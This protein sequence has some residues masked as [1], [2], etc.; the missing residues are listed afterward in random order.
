MGHR[1]IAV[2]KPIMLTPSRQA[3]LRLWLLLAVGALAVA[4]ALALLLALSRTPKIQDWLPW[5]SDFFH[6]GLVT[7]VV[8]SVV[9]WFL[10]MLGA[11]T[12]ATRP[13]GDIWAR[14]GLVAAAAGSLLLLVPTLAGWGDSSLNNYVPVLDHPL[15]YTGLALLGGGIALASAP[16]LRDIRLQAPVLEFGIAIGALGVISAL[17]C[18]GLA[19]ALIPAGTDRPFFNERLFWG[20]GHV[21]Q[22]VNTILMMAA[23]HAL[24]ITAFGRP[25]LPPAAARA[26]FASLGLFIL[27]APLLYGLDV[28]GL[29]HRVAFTQLLWYGLALPPLVMGLGVAWLLVTERSDT[30]AK[31]AL[32]LSLAVFG[33]G[34]VAGFFL[35]AGDTRTP[36]HYHAVIGGVNLA[37]MGMIHVHLLPAL[38][39]AAASRRLVRSQLWLYGGG[40]LLHAAGF[41]VAG[42][43]GIARKTA[44]SEQG[45]DSA[46]KL[47]SMG[48]VGLGGAIA[49]LGGVLFV[50]QV[51]ALLLRREAHHA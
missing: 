48:I 46:A 11:L 29:A 17:A 7:H 20:G 47:I 43:A 5:G 41:Y 36:S 23:W 26:V 16:S 30:T 25:A 44:G 37:L 9:V 14:A 32:A 42:M 1:G 51:L 34:G 38:G 13:G 19:W 39:R 28:Q 45:L 3:E 15:Y 2:S 35:G 4:G 18:F 8:F 27:A 33:L 31:L 6:K 50:I 10:A 22:F 24:A 49:V 12:A 40:Q 21:L